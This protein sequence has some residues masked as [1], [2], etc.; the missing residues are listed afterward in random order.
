MSQAHS[1]F[2]SSVVV[3][4]ADILEMPVVVARAQF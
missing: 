1:Q 2:L 4:A 3:A